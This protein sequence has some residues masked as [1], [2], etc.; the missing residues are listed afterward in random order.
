MSVILD[1]KELEVRNPSM[2]C[3]DDL[4]LRIMDGSPGSE[5][6]KSLLDVDGSDSVVQSLTGGKS[7]MAMPEQ[8][9]QSDFSIADFATNSANDADKD[10][11]DGAPDGAAKSENGKLDEAT[12]GADGL[13]PGDAGK[14]ANFDAG[15]IAKIQTTLFCDLANLEKQVSEE[16]RTAREKI[17]EYEAS[18]M[19]QLIAKAPS[20]QTMFDVFEMRLHLLEVV[21]PKAT[22]LAA[23]RSQPGHDKMTEANLDTKDTVLAKILEKGLDMNQIFA[24][25]EKLL[26]LDELQKAV[27]S[28]GQDVTTSEALTASKK[29]LYAN[30]IEPLKCLKIAVNKQAGRLA[31]AKT[32][33]MRQVAKDVPPKVSPDGD[34]AAQTKKKTDGKK[35]QAKAGLFASLPSE[36]SKPII[37]I[38]WKGPEC[39]T[40]LQSVLQSADPFIIINSN[41]PE[42]ISLSADIR[43]Q[44]LVFKSSVGE[45]NKQFVDNGRVCG[46]LGAKKQTKKTLRADVGK[47]IFGGESANVNLEPKELGKTDLDE[48]FGFAAKEN[49]QLTTTEYGQMG[50]MHFVLQGSMQVVLVDF[51]EL[52][53]FVS[54]AADA[55]VR[56]PADDTKRSKIPTIHPTKVLDFMRDNLDC[57][58]MLQEAGKHGV[59]FHTGTV[60]SN[61]ILVV[62]PAFVRN[63]RAIGK[64]SPTMSLGIPYLSRYCAARF[65][66]YKFVMESVKIFQK[67]LPE[68]SNWKLMLA[69]EKALS[70]VDMKCHV[71]GGKPRTCDE[72]PSY[73]SVAGERKAEQ[74]RL[75]RRIKCSLHSVPPRMIIEMMR[76]IV[77]LADR[78]KDTSG[79]TVEVAFVPKEFS[80][81]IG[82]S[83]SFKP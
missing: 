11:G 50:H 21:A 64:G 55:N 51:P 76:K 18:D 66:E 79:Y 4:V 52:S 29:A 45:K 31:S 22:R 33:A 42:K 38:D 71:G 14:K 39:Q 32:Q 37:V 47:S 6:D 60:N 77:A 62:P 26:D 34:Q 30:Q 46:A 28:F 63:Q 49:N 54:M 72:D 40:K 65:D 35:D 68:N 10:G 69:T 16:I 74:Q 24:D 7:F 3:I 5:L 59:R 58:D 41:L 70:D 2:A 8:I 81:S 15:E 19:S 9:Q 78:T 48:V 61:S 36:H 20:I 75:V 53:N 67:P 43:L 17:K 73:P 27:Q 56:G 12:K 80:V 25:H 83:T 1:L 13:Q 44:L 82:G 57:P 23:L